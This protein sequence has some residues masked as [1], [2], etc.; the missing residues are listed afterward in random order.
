MPIKIDDLKTI[1]NRVKSDVQNNLP[2]SQPFLANSFIGSMADGVAGRSY[3]NQRLIQ[4]AGLQAFP[5]TADGE[6]LEYL[7]ESERIFRTPATQSSGQIVITGTSGSDVSANTNY[8]YNGNTYKTQSTVT[9]GKNTVAISSLSIVS[10]NALA[11]ASNHNFATG[12]KVVISGASPDA[13]N[14]EKVI[15]VINANSFSYEIADGTAASASGNISATANM[16]L[17]NV[18]S[19]GYGKTQNVASGVKISIVTPLA[20]VDDEAIVASENI[21]GG[22]DEESLESVREKILYKRANPVA[23][24]NVSA[25][26]LKAK[27]ISG[28]TRVWVLECTPEVGKVTIYFMRD[29]DLNPI[30]SA[31]DITIVKNKILEIKPVTNEDEDVIVAALTPVPVNFRFQDI[32]PDSDSMRTAIKEYLRNFFDEESDRN[33]SIE[34]KEIESVLVNLIDVNTSTKLKDYTMLEPTEDIEVGTNEIAI[35][36]EVNFS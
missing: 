33:K 10:G 19:E 4:K 16:A 34:L 24:F 28:V 8:Q 15:N 21:D 36:G 22:T 20:G 17:A 23:N 3:E 29:D 11:V 5:Q 1:S 18:V 30:P 12:Q 14:G 13:Y 6:A 35:L 26:T 2:N 25:I 27:E 9:I 7:A 31:N 32:V